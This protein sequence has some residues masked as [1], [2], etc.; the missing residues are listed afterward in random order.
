MEHS[1]VI[2]EVHSINRSWGAACPKSSLQPLVDSG[3]FRR[4]GEREVPWPAFVVSVRNDLLAS[5]AAEIRSAL[6]IVAGYA[7]RL[8]T[9]AASAQLISDTYGLKPVDAERWLSTVEW[10][11]S[12]ERPDDAL[13]AV[14]AALA[15]QGAIESTDVDL[16]DLWFRLG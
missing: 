14:I 11:R 15:A 16:D 3:E 12:H 10:S 1:I 6:D 2:C 9:S 5:Q 8:K 4:V 13:R 7:R